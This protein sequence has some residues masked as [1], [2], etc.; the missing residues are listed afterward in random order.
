MELRDS[1]IIDVSKSHYSQ[2]RL[3]ST[4]ELERR[5]PFYAQKLASRLWILPRK[6][7]GEISS[8]L[9]RESQNWTVVVLSQERDREIVDQRRGFHRHARLYQIVLRGT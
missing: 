6:V 8:L 2:A 5:G 1:Y 4:Y 3:A 7:R 9:G